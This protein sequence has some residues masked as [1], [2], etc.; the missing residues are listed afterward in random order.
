MAS[1]GHERNAKNYRLAV[2][3]LERYLGTTRVMFTHLSSSV[4][5]RWINSLSLTN[6]AKEMYP[7][8]LR[9]IFKR[10]LI[11]LNDEE[12]GIVRIKYNPWLKV[13][14]P[15]S[16][17][18]VQR[19][20]SAEAC[21]EFFNR[22]LPETKMISSLPEL[23][24]DVALLSLCLGGINTVDIFELKKENYK[25]GIIGYK[26]AKTS[27]A[28]KTKPILK[29][30]WNRSFRPHLTSIFQTRMTNIFSNSISVTVTLTVSMPM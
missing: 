18:T 2:N 12:R 1:E 3:H 10:A 4:L 17:S 27:T 19:A 8:C 24:R 13:S 5:T 6:R 23:G 7:T 22:P 28:G 15:K 25:D 30:A 11:E 16:D 29:C 21:R 20:I 14:I 9:Q 26:R